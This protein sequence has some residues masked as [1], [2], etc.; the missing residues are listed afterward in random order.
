M[1]DADWTRLLLALLLPVVVLGLILFLAE[2]LGGRIG[3]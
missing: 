1:F 2:K 3:E